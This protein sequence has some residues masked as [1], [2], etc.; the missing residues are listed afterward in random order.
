MIEQH[1]LLG[2]RVSVWCDLAPVL[3]QRAVAGALADVAQYL[4]EG[5][6]LAHD[7]DD[8]V[9]QRRLAG[10]LRH[11]ARGDVP[12]CGQGRS[13]AV[14]PQCETIVL[15]DRRRIRGYL[16]ASRLRDDVDRS[17][18]AVNVPAREPPRP[19]HP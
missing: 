12:A 6:I 9:D 14:S 10:T 3:Q 19:P 11:G 1:E 17:A 4:V 16:S 5:P 2:E 18:I 15:C 13:R 8:V 7:I